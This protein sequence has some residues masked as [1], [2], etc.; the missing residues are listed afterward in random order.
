MKREHLIKFKIVR[1]YIKNLLDLKKK[2]PG[3]ADQKEIDKKARQINIGKQDVQDAHRL[4]NSS[5][6]GKTKQKGKRLLS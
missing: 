5:S 1:S 3:K 4:S 6:Q 2:I